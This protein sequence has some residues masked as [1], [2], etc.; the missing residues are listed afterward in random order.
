MRLMMKVML[1]WHRISQI[2]LTTRTMKTGKEKSVLAPSSRQHQ[3]IKMIALLQLLTSDCRTSLLDNQSHVT[4]IILRNQTWDPRFGRLMRSWIK[5]EQMVPTAESCPG[6]IPC[7]SLSVCSTHN[8]ETLTLHHRNLK[9]KNSSNV[10][11]T[12]SSNH[13]SGNQ[14]R[15]RHWTWQL[16]IRMD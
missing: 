16:V 7:F 14:T 11:V 2:S 6:L 13:H 5:T 10:T 1:R 8:Y 15:R 3:P 12:L 4:L 9:I